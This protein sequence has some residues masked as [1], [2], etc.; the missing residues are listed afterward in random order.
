MGAVTAGVAVAGGL[1]GL[2]QKQKE[3]KQQRELL[4]KQDA[5]QRMQADLQLFSLMQQRQTDN[6]SNMLTE[7]TQKQQFMQTQAMLDAQAIQQQIALTQSGLANEANRASGVAGLANKQ[8]QAEGE[9][10]NARLQAGA[11]AVQEISNAS[12]EEQGLI[13]SVLKQLQQTGSSQNSIA[14]LL[15]YAASAGGVNE[16]LEM[17]SGGTGQEATVAAANVARSSQI[18][19]QKSELAKA[20]ERAGVSLADVQYGLS[21]AQAAIEKQAVDYN[22]NSNKLNDETAYATNQ[23]G[24]SAAKSA[25]V[26]NYSI[27]NST[28]QLQQQSRYL[29]SLANENAIKQGSA[30]NSEIL[31]LQSSNIRTPGFLD[32]V[33]VGLQGYTNYRSLG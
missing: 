17:L 33:G 15:D 3:A 29:N 24:L 20:S 16:A 13:S 14:L 18:S 10:S 5:A 28:N 4:A 25:N 7:S 19:Q 21:N 23:A 26:A 30:I 27:M 22:Y 1:L 11:Q 9:R 2:N 32:Y 6:L 31:S 8:M 12:S